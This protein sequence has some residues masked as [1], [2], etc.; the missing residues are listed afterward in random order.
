MF[1]ADISDMIGKP[2]LLRSSFASCPAIVR[3][4]AMPGALI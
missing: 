1:R 3:K 4:H 2:A